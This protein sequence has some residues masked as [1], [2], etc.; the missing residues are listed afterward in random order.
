MSDPPRP[1]GLQPTRLLR[2]WEFPGKSAGVGCRSLL[3]ACILGGV[4]SLIRGQGTGWF[5][6]GVSWQQSLW[7]LVRSGDF[8]PLT[9]TGLHKKMSLA[10]KRMHSL[11]FPGASDGE[12]CVDHEGE[13]VSIPESGRCPGGGHGN[14]LQ[15]SC[16]ENPMDRG[17]GRAAVHGVAKSQ[18]RL[19]D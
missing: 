16:L 3:R 19:S 5:T 17:A 6:S 7:G 18:T 14:P 2:P 12:A 11:G 15:C 13:L 10:I 8:C 1:H 4:F 9:G